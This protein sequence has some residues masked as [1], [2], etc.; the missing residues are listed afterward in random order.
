MQTDPSAD[1][2][3]LPFAVEA[4][5]VTGRWESLAKFTGRFQEDLAQDFNMSV[6]C[7]FDSLY[8][9]YGSDSLDKAI[10]GMRDRIASS[11]TTSATASLNSAHE[12]LLKCH[13]LTDLE[14]IVKTKPGN[15]NERRKTLK[16]LDGRLELIGG[17]FSDK[18]YLLGIRRAAMELSRYGQ[19]ICTLLANNHC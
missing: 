15:E 6:A 4:A 8:R 7:L 17:Q 11:M 2:K 5:W 1:I 12:I 13:V 18:Q 10:Q 19:R 3:I 9:H 14:V 16:L